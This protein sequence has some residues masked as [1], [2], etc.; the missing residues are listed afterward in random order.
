MPGGIESSKLTAQPLSSLA[1]ELRALHRKTGRTLRE[2]EKVALASDS[3]LSRYLG[4]KTLPPWQVVEAFCRQAGRDPAELRALWEHA[5][6]ARGPARQPARAPVPA[7]PVPAAPAPTVPAPAAPHGPELGRW[8]FIAA[9][10]ACLAAL[11]TRWF[12]PPGGL[13]LQ[14]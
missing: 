5:K 6:A 3:S 4:A 13:H 14:G 12:A 9:A 7:A 2:M 11:M 8:V 1:A 10:A